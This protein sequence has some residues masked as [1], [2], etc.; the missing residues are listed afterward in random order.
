MERRLDS[1]DPDF[2]F[3][4]SNSCSL[5]K[6]QILLKYDENIKFMKSFFF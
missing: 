6:T 1:M 5:I 2:D 3:S 4:S